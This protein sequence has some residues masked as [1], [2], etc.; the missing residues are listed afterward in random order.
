M[1][2]VNEYYDGQVKSIA[3]NSNEGPATLGVMA[4]G[5]YE[6]S[7]SKHEVMQVVSGNMKVKLP[8][9]E[10][11]ENFEAG[12]SFNVPANSSFRLEI[13]T[14]SAYLCLYK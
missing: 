11:W 4:P 3:F 9:R 1:F 7:T 5:K 10:N 8:D 14:E 13:T 12:R 6:F 2:K